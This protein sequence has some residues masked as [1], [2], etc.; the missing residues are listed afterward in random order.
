MCTP[1][2]QLCVCKATTYLIKQGLDARQSDWPCWSSKPHPSPVCSSSAQTQPLTSQLGCTTSSWQT[3]TELSNNHA[4]TNPGSQG[5][6]ASLSLTSSTVP[7]TTLAPASSLSPSPLVPAASTAPCTA[8]ES[9]SH[10]MVSL[11]TSSSVATP[12]TTSQS[13]SVTS[14]PSLPKS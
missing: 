12:P 5:T 4:T 13:P 3:N 14:L 1:F 6:S 9:E 7:V 11:P 10:P 8:D 2:R